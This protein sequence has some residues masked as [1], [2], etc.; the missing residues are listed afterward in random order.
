MRGGDG[1]DELVGEG[2]PE[3]EMS[4]AGAETLINSWEQW[5]KPAILPREKWG[6]RRSLGLAGPANQ[7]S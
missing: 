5:H 1:K 7:A 4:Q 2:N 3:R 6:T